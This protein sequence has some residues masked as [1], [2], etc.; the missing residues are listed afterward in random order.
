MTPEA[1]R[2]R[3]R[4]THR[5]IPSRYPPSGILDR[6]A[7]P[8]DLEMIFEL[9]GWTNDRISTELGLLHTI[10]REEW[11]VGRAMASVVMAAYCHPRPGGGRFNLSDRGAWYAA[12]SL[13]TAH[14][15]AAHHRWKELAEVGVLD[16]RLEMRDYLADFDAAFRD[17]RGS[18]RAYARLRDP[19]D[20]S[21]SQT[22]ARELLQAGSNGI[23]YRSVRDPGGE[24]VVCFRP[25]LVR[26]VRMAAHFE[27]RFAGE[28][29][30]A[31]R[32]LGR[33]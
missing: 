15:E 24:C 21:A 6:I 8:A 9:E 5:L 22:L 16:A 33:G 4:A 30:P 10:P 25:R 3:R 32:A 7:D 26:N 2:L 28:P 18:R 31:I 14:A 17:V 13:E 27:Y 1:V 12:V 11:V 20:Y 29:M 23:V 19:V